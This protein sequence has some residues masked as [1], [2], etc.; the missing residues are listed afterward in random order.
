MLSCIVII[1]L[2]IAGFY[3]NYKDPRPY[4]I[5]LTLSVLTALTTYK[6]DIL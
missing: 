1:T 2:S 4:A 3:T 5:I 6:F